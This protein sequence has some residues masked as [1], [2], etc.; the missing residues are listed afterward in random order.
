MTVNNMQ[1]LR[2]ALDDGKMIKRL[3][4]KSSYTPDTTGT[5]MLLTNVAGIPPVI[6]TPSTAVVPDRTTTG[7]IHFPTPQGSNNSFIMGM[8]HT[9]DQARPIMLADILS[10][11]GG[12]SGTVITAQ[13]T[14]LP[15]AA[16]TRYTD[17]VGVMLGLACWTATGSTAVNVT[18]S[19]T[20]QAGT[21]GRTTVSVNFWGGGFGA[22]SAA[23]TAT[24]FQALPL[25]SGDYGVRAV[26][27]VTLSASTLT[28]GNFGVFL[29]KPLA[30]VANYVPDYTGETEYI[31]HSSMM[32]EIQ[33]N[34]FL[35]I[36]TGM[37]GTAA[38]ITAGY[39][40]ILQV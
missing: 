40:N 9:S 8:G 25:Q 13:T 26:A 3:F 19:Y 28:A 17:G 7:A 4:S 20:N 15:T 36:L 27:S 18:A 33:D 29:F 2:Q 38:T 6:T 35:T 10:W 1:E 37:S 24:Q 30:M 31:V 5:P 16:L 23:P 32:S 12:L 14:N 21:T 39:I 11:Q 34:A 22:V